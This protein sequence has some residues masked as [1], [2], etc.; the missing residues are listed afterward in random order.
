M[1]IDSQYIFLEIGENAPFT[2]T[3]KHPVTLYN[4][5]YSFYL[6]SH[7]C[8]GDDLVENL[9]NYPDNQQLQLSTIEYDIIYL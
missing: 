6:D 7:A 2:I 1:Y 9:A 5:K 8:F 4:G 3:D